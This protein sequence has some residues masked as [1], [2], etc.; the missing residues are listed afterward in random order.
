LAPTKTVTEN[1]QDQTLHLTVDKL[2]DHINNKIAVWRKD[3]EV[4]KKIHP[5]LTQD[6]IDSIITH[7]QGEIDFLR[8]LPPDATA[9]QI[10]NDHR[11]ANNV[12]ESLVEPE[13]NNKTK[14]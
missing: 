14:D 3:G 1:P 7:L 8:N 10:A 13:E 5:S 9:E 4:Y 2:I 12:I 6:T 11:S